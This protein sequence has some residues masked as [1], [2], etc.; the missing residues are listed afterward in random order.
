MSWTGLQLRGFARGVLPT[1]L[2]NIRLM[3]EGLPDVGVPQKGRDGKL[4]L[5]DYHVV[6]AANAFS[7]FY[8]FVGQHEVTKI[9]NADYWDDDGDYRDMRQLGGHLGQS[10]ASVHWSYQSDTAG[11][12]THRYNAVLGYEGSNNA[13]AIAW[14]NFSG[15]AMAPSGSRLITGASFFVTSLDDLQQ[16]FGGRD[17]HELA[18]RIFAMQNGG[19]TSGVKLAERTSTEPNFSGD[20]LIASSKYYPQ[21]GQV[22]L[23]PLPWYNNHFLVVLNNTLGHRDWT[24]HYAQNGLVAVKDGSPVLEAFRDRAGR[25]EDRQ[26]E[27]DWDRISRTHSIHDVYTWLNR[28]VWQ[29]TGA[30]T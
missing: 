7:D 30:G 29:A 15:V 28:G 10:N 22:E 14:R 8:S 11:Q 1:S 25:P 13:E 2:G 3:N 19:E 20:A 6:H 18:K 21:L 17:L 27:Q 23:I 4:S 16:R 5:D 26:A 12:P 24:R 9:L